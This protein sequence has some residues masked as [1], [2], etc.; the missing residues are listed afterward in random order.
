MGGRGGD[1]VR[2][3]FSGMRDIENDI[4]RADLLGKSGALDERSGLGGYAGE[5]ERR[6]PFC[7][8]AV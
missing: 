7:E 4:F 3:P 1:Y 5:D 8:H 2:Y 6:A